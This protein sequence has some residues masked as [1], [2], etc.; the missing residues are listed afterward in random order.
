MGLQ[1]Y[2]NLGATGTTRGW[3]PVLTMAKVVGGTK[4]VNNVS[5]DSAYNQ[6]QYHNGYAQSA[7]V[8]YYAYYN[9]SGYVRMKLVGT[10]VCSDLNC[11]TQTP[12]TLTTIVQTDQTLNF[13]TI[14]NYKL[15]SSIVTTGTSGNN[16]GV[17]SSIKVGTTSVPSANFATPLID[18]ATITRDSNNTVT[19]SCDH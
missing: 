2:T 1:Y 18:H 10:A 14:D 9:Y 12:T 17:Y 4:T 5:F 7:S 16:T 19:I 15:I 3:K 13:T 6:V 8:N 11:N